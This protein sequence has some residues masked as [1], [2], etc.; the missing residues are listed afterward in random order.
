MGGGERD[1][2]DYRRRH[3]LPG[4]L[5]LLRRCCY[6]GSGG[7]VRDND[8]SDAVLSVFVARDKLR[9][10]ELKRQK[11]RR[12]TPLLPALFAVVLVLQEPGEGEEGGSKLAM[13]SRDKGSLPLYYAYEHSPPNWLCLA[14]QDPSS[15][16]R[17][18][19]ICSRDVYLSKVFV[20]LSPSSDV[21]HLGQTLELILATGGRWKQQLLCCCCLK[22]LNEP[23]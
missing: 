11:R 21:Y 4:L 5:P 10:R 3:Q 16:S 8:V 23:I 7:R 12:G 14:V 18:T 22:V 19:R 9:R 20:L 1:G 15:P 6:N 13:P 2:F 17:F